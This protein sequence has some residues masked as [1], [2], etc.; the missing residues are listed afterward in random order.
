MISCTDFTLFVCSNHFF[1]PVQCLS[2]DSLHQNLPIHGSL[3]DV[4]RKRFHCS[5]A[6][7]FVFL[8]CVCALVALF[9]PTVGSHSSLPDYLHV[10]LQSK[11]VA[12]FV[13]GKCSPWVSEESRGFVG[14]NTCIWYSLPVSSS[15]IVGLVTMYVI[16][17]D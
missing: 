7:T 3:T 1:H 10:S 15:F 16:R 8:V 12:A 5:F 2:G 11:L 14:S 4:R 17:T 6:L 13:L 9:L